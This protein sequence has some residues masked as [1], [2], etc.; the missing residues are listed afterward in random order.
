MTHLTELKKLNG[1]CIKKVLRVLSGEWWL[2]FFS[3]NICL[4]HFEVVAVHSFSIYSGTFG[5]CR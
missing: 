5:H 2:I 1:L 3:L 4:A